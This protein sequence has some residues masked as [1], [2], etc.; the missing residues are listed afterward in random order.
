MISITLSALLMAT[1][2]IADTP[3]SG[4]PDTT[5]QRPRDLREMVFLT[6][7]QGMAYGPAADHAKQTGDG[8]R[9]LHQRIRYA[10]G[11]SCFHAKRHL[12]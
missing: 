4:A 11:L 10:C 3:S 9:P 2:V 6:S 7:G 5:L 1:T 8:A 12:A